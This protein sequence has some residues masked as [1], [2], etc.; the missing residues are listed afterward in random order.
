MNERRADEAAEVLRHY[1]PEP[2]TARLLEAVAAA[3]IGPSATPEEL[4]AWDQFHLGGLPATAELAQALGPAPGDHVLDLGSGLGGPARLLAAR[5]DCRVTGVDLSGEFVDSANALTD[6]AGMADRVHCVR[7]DV[8]AVP[9]DAAAFDHAWTIHVAMNVADRRAF[10]GEAWRMLKGGGRFAMYDVIADDGEPLA[11]P[12][13]WATDPSTSHLVDAA[14]TRALLADAGFE[15]VSFEDR[16][17]ATLEWLGAIGD[18][19]PQ[20]GAGPVGLAV[21]MGPRFA[22]MTANLGRNLK[23]GRVGVIRTVVVKPA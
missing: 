23:M 6:L 18:R 3:G 7:G 17:E 15:E 9:F 14:G 4:G 13:P 20:P 12:V 21:A 2:L 22:E 5:Y 16:T 1:Q 8:T 10:Y 11:F 19:A